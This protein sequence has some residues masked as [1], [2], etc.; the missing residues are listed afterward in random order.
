MAEFQ[1]PPI[2]EEYPQKGSGRKLFSHAWMQWFLS[3]YN[4]VA[5][6]AK[7]FLNLDDTP[8]TYTSQA[9]KRVVVNA[10][11]TGLEFIADE[12]TGLQDTPANYTGAGKKIVKVNTGGTALEFGTIGG[13]VM[14]EYDEVERT[15]TGL[16]LTTIVYKLAT[17]TVETETRAYDSMDRIS[18]CITTNGGQTKTYTYGGNGFVTETV[19]T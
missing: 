1:Y 7:N 8:S 5:D 18:T 15:Y 9:T 12:F 14:P 19:I 6:F 13:M 2:G 16:L 10:G 4:N 3:I 11:E 17:S